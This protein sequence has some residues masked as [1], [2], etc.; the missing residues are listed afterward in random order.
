MI[1]QS[2]EY[3]NLT[4]KIARATHTNPKD[5]YLVFKARY[6]MQVVFDSICDMYPDSY[7]ATQSFTC[8]TAV[9]PIMQA[10]LEPLYIDLNQNNFALDYKQIPSFENIKCAVL[11]NTFGIVDSEY[12]Q[13][14]VKDAHEHNRIVLEDCAHSALRLSVDSL[15]QP[16]CDVSIHSFGVE[17]FFPHTFFGGA[18]WVNP[19]MEDKEL[20][21]KI[22]NELASLPEINK[23]ISKAVRRYHN[24]LRILNRLPSALK[25][26]MR[27]RWESSGKFEP[28][29][30]DCERK[31]KLSYAPMAPDRWICDRVNAHLDAYN[32]ISETRIEAVK[33]YREV[34]SHSKHN[35]QL[36]RI[37][38]TDDTQPYLRFACVFSNTKEAEHAIEKAWEKGFYLVPWYR[39]LLYPG[40]EDNK[41]YFLTN[42]N[43]DNST[44]MRL[45][46]GIV[47]LPTDVSA[48][49]ARELALLMCEL[50]YQGI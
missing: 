10:G 8:C 34:F 22:V 2:Q 13:A 23:S 28:A 47:C 3:V 38:M 17:K 44:T 24:Q 35:L 33:I 37:Q 16:L 25:G 4:D 40:I 7:V 32:E 15:N 31:G 45:S 19:H 9:D 26:A 48:E 42:D 14:F 12:A 36:S 39:P 6:G 18:V 43:V 20:Y 41:A 50:S 46:Q 29:V 49:R 5:W 1:Q 21:N 27:R 30:A 11:Q